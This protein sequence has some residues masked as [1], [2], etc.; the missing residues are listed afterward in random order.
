MPPSRRSVG[1]ARRRGA[2]ASASAALAA[3][4][5]V[6]LDVRAGAVVGLVG[7][8]GSGKTTL[9]H[10]VAGLLSV[11]AGTILVAGS[12]AGSRAARAASALVPDEP[13]GFDELSVIE[14]VSLVHALWGA[15]ERATA[16]ADGAPDGVRP[17]R[18]PRPEARNA[19]PRPPAA[20]ECGCGALARAAADPRR[21]GDRHARPGGDR[22]PQRGRRDA[23]GA[24][25]RRPA[26]HPGSA[27]R[28]L[29]VP[30]DRV[31]PSRRRDRPWRAGRL[32]GTAR[33]RLPRGGLPDGARRPARFAKGSEMRSTLCEAVARCHLRRL[34]GVAASA[35]LPA[36]IVALVVVTAPVILFR[37]GGAV[38]AEVADGIGAAGVSEP[39]CSDRCWQ[40][41]SRAPRSRSRHRR[42]RRS[43]LRSPQAR[44]ARWS[45]SSR[46]CLFPRLPARSSSCRRSVAVCIGLACALPG[47]AVAGVALAAATLAAVPAGAVVAEG[48]IAAGAQAA[49]PRAGRRR[50]SAG[51]ARG[52]ARS[53][54]CAA[55]AARARRARPSVAPA[56]PGSRS[57]CR[58]ASGSGSLRCWVASRRHAVQSRDRAVER[59]G[60]PAGDA[61]R[62]RSPRQCCW[63][64]GAI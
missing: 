51:L 62:H 32:A 35:P 8:N 21:R 44:R 10:A 6:D 57:A 5:G 1:T 41:P 28:G 42:D 53:R 30:R 4:D 19:L 31:A 36:A 7:P 20:G 15:G 55:R 38:G 48:G 61:C 27:L 22:R 17:R 64:G 54:S 3:L 50:R 25:V 46:S 11:D 24:R 43:G 52:R 39:S 37:L 56:L 26:R 23:G 45:P 9:L 33:R 60:A 12:P 13:T 40:P 63:R 58:V 14:L 16:R 59:W 18:P 47:G 34:R 29:R 49:P 2:S